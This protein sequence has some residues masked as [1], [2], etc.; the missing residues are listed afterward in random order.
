[1]LPRPHVPFDIRPVLGTAQVTG[2]RDGATCSQGSILIPRW[3]GTK[4]GTVTW[5]SGLLQWAGGGHGI[6]LV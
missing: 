4:P 3:E 1:M 5:G 2:W 6:L